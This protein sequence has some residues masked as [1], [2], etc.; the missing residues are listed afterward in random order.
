[1][2]LTF[3][4]AHC[5]TICPTVV[6]T[7]RAALD[8]TAGV[9]PA[10]WIVTLDPWRDTPGAL[11]GL[12]ARWQL[13]GD[14]M[15]VLSADVDTVL[16]VLDAYHVPHQRNLQ[17]GDITHPALVYIMDATGRIAYAFNNPS[18][19]WLVEAVRRL[20]RHDPS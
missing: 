16:G 6:Q 2:L 4:F 19:A 12:A 10:L 15:R 13:D 5:E 7:A 14:K 17:T 8:I 3:A 20:A 11:P 1:M 18:R 9:A